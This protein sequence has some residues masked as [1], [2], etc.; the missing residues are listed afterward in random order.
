MAATDPYTEVWHRIVKVINKH[1]RLWMM[2]H[3]FMGDRLEFIENEE[4]DIMEHFSCF[5][6]PPYLQTLFRADYNIKSKSAMT[7]DQI[8]PGKIYVFYVFNHHFTVLYFP[9]GEI[10]YVDFYI[11]TGR[12]N[13]LRFERM[14]QQDFESMYEVMKHTDLDAIA[15]FH[16]GDKNFHRDVMDQAVYYPGTPY[17]E[18]IKI[19]EMADVPEVSDLIHFSIFP[20]TTRRLVF[21]LS[22][23]DTRDYGE[24]NPD[25]RKLIL[26]YLEL[27]NR[28]VKIVS[29]YFYDDSSDGETQEF[30]L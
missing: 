1:P 10:W 8:S 16:R 23:N 29:E 26:R 9:S 15:T 13:P 24:T 27:L 19:S 14:N 20:H 22:R 17:I 12:E 18:E 25:T 11:E 5:N 2:T 4:N 6:I 3:P 7:F 28:W 21:E 30:E